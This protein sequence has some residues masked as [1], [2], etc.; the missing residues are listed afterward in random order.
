MTK[1]EA[2]RDFKNKIAPRVIARYGRNDRPALREAWNDWTDALCKDGLITERQY[3]SWVYEP[4]AKKV[5]PSRR[6]P[7]R[8]RHAARQAT[9]PHALCSEAG[10]CIEPVSGEERCR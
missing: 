2:I 8:T 3:D 10:R 7:K 6:R 9:T 4:G 1:V 5:P